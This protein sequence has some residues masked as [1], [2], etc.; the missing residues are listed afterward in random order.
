VIQSLDHGHTTGDFEVA[1][2]EVIGVCFESN[3]DDT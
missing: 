2:E 3:A 1:G